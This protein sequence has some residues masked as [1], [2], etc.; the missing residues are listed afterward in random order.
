MINPRTMKSLFK[1]HQFE[2]F[3]FKEFLVATGLTMKQVVKIDVEDECSKSI[4]ES[5]INTDCHHNLLKFHEDELYQEVLKEVQQ[6]R[7]EVEERTK[8]QMVKYYGT[9]FDGDVE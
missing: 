4:D 3:N 9:S 6:E 7:K 1:P 8:R 5:C 2:T